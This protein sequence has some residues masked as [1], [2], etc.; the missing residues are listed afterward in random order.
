MLQSYPINLA[1]DDNGTVVARFPD[2]PEAMTVGVDENNA[3]EWAQDALVVALSG[4][5][6]GHRDIP[7]PSKPEKGQKS[8][9]LPPQVAMKLSIYQAMRDQ[10]VTQSALGECVGVDG[11]QVRRILDLD[12]NTSLAQLVRAL[13]CLGKKLILDIR[14]AA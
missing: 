2:V 4:Y 5:M 3:T 6:D 10:G 8:V 13:Q 9:P 7:A 1:L 12:H 14:D 11:R